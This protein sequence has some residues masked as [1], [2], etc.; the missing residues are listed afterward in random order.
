MAST[1]QNEAAIKGE[2]FYCCQSCAK[3]HTG[4]RYTKG[5]TCIQCILIRKNRHL[6]NRQRSKE[7]VRLARIAT[8]EGCTTYVPEKPC[9]FG[10]MLRFVESN[11]CVDCDVVQ[12]NKHKT[13]AKFSRIRKDYGLSK[14][15]YLNLVN[16]QEN[17]CKLCFAYI[18]NHFNMHIDHCHTTGRVRGLLC[19][20]C[21]QGIGL[22]NHNPKLLGAAADY[23]EK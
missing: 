17:K 19:G 5:G 13:N 15:D 6:D 7:N 1:S 16:E 20:K 22:L 4:K 10:H 2:V 14:E 21:N 9:K 18:E 3:G 8:N 11:N 23:C 12:R